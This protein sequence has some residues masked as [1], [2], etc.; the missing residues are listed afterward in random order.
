MRGPKCDPCGTVFQALFSR[1][2]LVPRERKR[3]G[4]MTYSHNAVIRRVSKKNC[5]ELHSRLNYRVKPISRKEKKR[6]NL[7]CIPALPYLSNKEY[8]LPV[9]RD[10]MK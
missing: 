4:V 9:Y 2:I 7:D 6:G 3:L 1:K 8:M 5:S 10:T